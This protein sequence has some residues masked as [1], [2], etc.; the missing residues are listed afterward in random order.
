MTPSR[1]APRIL[2]R[3][4]A[5]ARLL[6]LLFCALLVLCLSLTDGRGVRPLPANGPIRYETHD[7]EG[8]TATFSLA[9]P[10]SRVLVTY[11]GATELL[12]DLGLESRIVGAIRPYGEE[13]PAY[14]ERYAAL[15]LL[16][17]PYVPSREEVLALRS[18]FIIGW[19]HHFTPEALG[20][21][22]GYAMR[23]I[24]TYIVPA[25]VRK[26][27]PTLDA[28]VYPFIEDMGRIFGAEERAAICA[29]RLR[30]RQTAVET[31]AA[32]RRRRY[33]AM[34]LQSHGNSLYSMY[35][36]AYI[37]DDIARR[38]GADNV[39]RRQMRSVGPERVL[40]F[41][42]EVII[43]VNPRD[44]STEEARTAL[45]ADPNLRNMRAVRD[46]HII[47]IPFADVNNG[48]G[49]CIDALEAISAGLDAIDLQES[50]S[51]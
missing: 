51:M 11:P 35:G 36:P 16:A 13:S 39:V 4:R 40:A 1:T 5:A 31:R 27:A 3:L 21:V 28:T 19:S 48:N 46:G 38:A 7:S 18:D 42:P 26:G 34:I 10:P 45:R 33:S 8:H 23:G 44:T 15:P 12:I 47:V 6:P 49:R 32:E 14:A 2:R 29:D 17:A 9:H 30:A 24:G 20:D 50:S 22:Y 43:Y 37:I 41:T 25:T